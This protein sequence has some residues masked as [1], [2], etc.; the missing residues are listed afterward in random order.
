VGFLFASVLIPSFRAA[1]MRAID[2]LRS[3]WYYE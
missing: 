1:N 2:A 3:E